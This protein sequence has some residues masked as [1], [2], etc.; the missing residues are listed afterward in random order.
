MCR[1]F[2]DLRLD[3]ATAPPGR[4]LREVSQA[5][6][7]YDRRTR[8]VFDHMLEVDIRKLASIRIQMK[9][10]RLTMEVLDGIIAATSQILAGDEEGECQEDW[11]KI[12]RADEWARQERDRR[13]KKKRNR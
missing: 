13:N 8:E 9:R 6:R 12:D 7:T 10:A 1:V 5:A 4:L 3:R 11:D 2:S